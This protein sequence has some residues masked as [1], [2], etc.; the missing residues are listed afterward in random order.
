MLSSS[1]NI[2]SYILAARY[3]I[4][5]ISFNIAIITLKSS[6]PYKILL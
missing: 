2:K 3:I 6:I 5:S 4:S 1:K